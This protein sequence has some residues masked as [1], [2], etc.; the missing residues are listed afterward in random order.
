MGETRLLPSNFFLLFVQY[1]LRTYFVLESRILHNMTK[2][3]SIFFKNKK[4]CIPSSTISKTIEH[5]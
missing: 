3:K 2:S 5:F 4:F 1:D